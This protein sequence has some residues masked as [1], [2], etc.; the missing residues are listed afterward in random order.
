[1]RETARRIGV[2]ETTYREWEY[3]RKICGAEPY[4]KIARAFGISISELFG[5]DH[6]DLSVENRIERIRADA[7]V[8]KA[9]VA[10]LKR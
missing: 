8:V 1:M 9:A 3:G 6:S 2:P 4:R 10:K 7:E 5:E